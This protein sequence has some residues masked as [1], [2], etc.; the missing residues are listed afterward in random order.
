MLNGHVANCDIMQ[1]AKTV[2][3][4]L[5]FLGSPKGID[6]DA[7]KG[8][9]RVGLCTSLSLGGLRTSLLEFQS[10]NPHFQTS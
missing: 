8:L 7:P 9:L 10:R 1:T 2:L 6:A 5:E 4:Q 3:E